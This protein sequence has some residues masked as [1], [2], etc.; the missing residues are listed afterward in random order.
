MM[1]EYMKC[2]RWVADNHATVRPQGVSPVHLLA[3]VIVVVGVV[4][5]CREVVP[6]RIAVAA[7]AGAIA[8]AAV[9][10]SGRCFSRDW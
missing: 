9:G 10:H 5:I 6:I 8:A 2:A 7:T 3:V 1:D 4:P